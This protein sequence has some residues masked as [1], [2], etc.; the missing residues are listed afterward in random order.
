MNPGGVVIAIV[1][2]WAVTQ[3]LAG[4]ALERMLILPWGGTPATT[5]PAS[6]SSSSTTVTRG[7]GKASGLMTWGTP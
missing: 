3:V 5:T 2:I 4:E 7:L 1:G 6:T